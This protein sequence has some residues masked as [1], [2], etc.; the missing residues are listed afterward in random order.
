MYQTTL[1]NPCH[2]R[3]IGLHSGT[4][5]SLTL[6]PAPPNHGVVFR[7]VGKSG[8]IEIPARMEHVTRTQLSTCLGLG[9]TEVCTVEHLLAALRGLEIDNVVI[10]TQGSEIPV[11]DGSAMPFVRHVLEAGRKVQPV[12]RRYIRLLA[13]LRVAE[14]EKAVELR[15]SPVTVYG[16]Q[17]EFPHPAIRTQAFELRLTPQSFVTELAASRTF[18]FEADIEALREQGLALGASLENAVGLGRNGAVLN[19]GGLRYP[20]EFVRHKLLDA[21]GDLSLLPFPLVA[22]YRGVRA[23]HSINLKLLQALAARPDLWEVTAADPLQH[24]RAAV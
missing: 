12:L 20:D 13:P 9:E 16:L 3:G 14:G 19:E 10:L 8:T 22:E 4:E 11:M 15:P 17:I 2:I 5:A 23:G 21:V 1:R 7:V 6:L 24:A 18:G